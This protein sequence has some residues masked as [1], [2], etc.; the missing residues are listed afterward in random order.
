MRLMGSIW[1]QLV[2]LGFAS[3]LVV[4]IAGI[5]LFSIAERWD[6]TILPTE[7]TLR[8]YLSAVK[9]P[10]VL[11]S[12]GRSLVISLLTVLLS[13]TLVAPTAY[14]SRVFAP[15][16]RP[17]L[18][19]AALLPFAIPGVILAVGLIEIYSSAPMR[20]ANTVWILLFSYFVVTLPFMYNS[21]GNAIDAVDIKTL[22][23]AAM[24]L[25]ASQTQVLR[26]IVLPN[27]LPGV[28]AGSLLTFVSAVGEFTLANLLVGTS[29]KTF[30][31]HLAQAIPK[32]GHIASALVSLYFAIVAAGS[33]AVVRLG[34][35]VGGRAS[36]GLLS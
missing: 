14:M 32:E 21:V 16:L 36:M 17:W 20:I 3:Y 7:Y 9:S 28:V 33:I 34:A 5:F 11:S 22:S 12:V 26:T 1:R 4:P 27:I 8:W 31:V 25:G 29:Y 18:D 15:R 30:Q 23:Q 2:I 24:I 13:V 19:L 35:G 10:G 6:G